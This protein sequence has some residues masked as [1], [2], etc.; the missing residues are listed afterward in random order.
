MENQVVN[1]QK[2]N[3][4]IVED[5]PEVRFYSIRTKLRPNTRQKSSE[6]FQSFFANPGLDHIGRKILLNLDVK[7]LVKYKRVN[8]TWK[9]IIDS[10]KFWVKWGARLLQKYGYN[11]HQFWYKVIETEKEDT[12]RLITRCRG[13][14]N[15]CYHFLTHF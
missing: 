8:K 12:K 14:E 4:N 2:T 3:S 10:P 1:V 7:S 9:T 6:I 11:D 13:Y 5:T 15:F